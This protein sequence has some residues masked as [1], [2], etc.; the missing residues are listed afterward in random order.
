[1]IYPPWI[2]LRDTLSPSARM[3]VKLNNTAA[4]IVPRVMANIPIGSC[5]HLFPAT[6]LI[7][8]G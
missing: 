1:M 5:F 7:L 6:L 8:R 3:L 4:L 2:L